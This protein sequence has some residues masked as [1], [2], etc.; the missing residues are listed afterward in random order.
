MQRT[1][2][3]KIH[4]F[5]RDENGF[6]VV[7]ALPTRAGIFTYINADG[8]ERKELRHP[9]EVFK[10]ESMN[11]LKGKP[12]T[13]LHPQAGKVNSKNSKG[14]MVGFSTEEVSK[15]DENYIK[16]T[17][18]ITDE[19]TIQKIESGRQVELSCGYSTDV[20][21][22]SG[23]YNGEKFDCKQTNI[24]YNHIATVPRGRAG[25]KS[26]IYCDSLEDAASTDFEISLREDE[27]MTT[28]TLVQLRVDAAQVGTLK[29]DE[30]NFKIDEEFQPH[31]QKAIDR[32]DTLLAH[33]KTL[34][35]KVDAQEGTIDELKTK[36]DKAVDPETLTDMVKERADILGVAGHVG[37]K[38]FDDKS[39]S[40]LKKAVVVARNDGLNL[41]DKAD[42][43]ID[44]R[45]DAVVEQ[46]KQD[47]KAFKSL[48]LLAAVTKPEEGQRKD[49][50]GEEK[51][52]ART[53]YMI[54]TSDMYKET[55][56]TA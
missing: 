37:L 53:Q 47:T 11:T 49:E 52:D 8:S 39:N 14:L 4:G 18:N 21:D 42:A 41:D 30:L 12:V 35:D 10:A 56:K 26:R 2:Q 50:K 43:Y 46:I 9:D 23:E 54:D 6:L 13:D 32:A 38:D 28:K 55:L 51:K 1:D 25:A 20:I 24:K 34:Q 5:K 33:A 44:A 22:E 3:I 16:T 31:L 45:Y 36:A 27:I 29:V 48:A 15:T 17:L 7:N 40:D 19:D